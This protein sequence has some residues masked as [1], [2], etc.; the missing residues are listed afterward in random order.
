MGQTHQVPQV[1]EKEEMNSQ[2]PVD[3][4]RSERTVVKARFNG[5][6]KGEQQR[7]SYSDERFSCVVAA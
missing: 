5:T 3:L 1:D 7:G 2:I 6:K 4:D